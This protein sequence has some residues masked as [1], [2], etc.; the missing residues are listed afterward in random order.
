M[1]A[2]PRRWRRAP[3]ATSS[4]TT[5]DGTSCTALGHRAQEGEGDAAHV[6]EPDVR[7]NDEHD[8]Q[9][10]EHAAAPGCEARVREDGHADC[11][12]A[13]DAGREGEP[14]RRRVR[15]GVRLRGLRAPGHDMVA[16]SAREAHM[17]CWL[18]GP[19]PAAPDAAAALAH[20][21]A[22]LFKMLA[23]LF[24]LALNT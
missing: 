14:Q 17:G 8:G 7:E 10:R 21:V 5:G 1:C 3:T 16:Q 6:Q 22:N 13:A 18:G 4:W 2:T 11:R 19:S 23:T 12:H 24:I 9:R 15:H 20:A